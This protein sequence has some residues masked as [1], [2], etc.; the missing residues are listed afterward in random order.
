MIALI[1]AGGSGTRLWPLSRALYSKQFIT[2]NSKLSLL[3]HTVKGAVRH[4]EDV[5]IV[6]G[7]SQYFLVKHQLQG[8]G[9][10]EENIL[11]EPLGRN[12]APAIAFGC[13]F[14][15]E[16]HGESEVLVMPSD[17]IIAEGFFDVAKKAARHS[18]RFIC[19]F[20]I[21]PT[22]PSTGYGYIR[23]GEKKDD[24]YL[25]KGFYEKPSREK[26]EEYLAS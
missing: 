5:V 7:E 24:G 6:T 16:K 8:F 17:H 13:K 21:T 20:G 1:L 9:V 3:Q 4:C 15:L 22:H 25:V 18:S 26:A 2:F 10:S 23:V 11:K 14:I 12:T 19:T